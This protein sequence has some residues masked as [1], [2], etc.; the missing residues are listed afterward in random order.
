MAFLP[1]YKTYIPVYRS[2]FIGS[3]W[4]I[5]YN[6]TY[7]VSFSPFI[8][9]YNSLKSFDGGWNELFGITVILND[10]RQGK[11]KHWCLCIQF[12]LWLTHYKK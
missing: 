8:C 7:G 11:W 4:N 5:P 2:I 1:F 10:K 3:I 6:S 9:G 12:T